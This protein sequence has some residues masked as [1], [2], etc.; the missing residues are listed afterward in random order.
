VSAA[1]T[2][3][4]VGRLRLRLRAYLAGLWQD[5]AQAG[6]CDVVTVLARPLPSMAI[7]E[8][9]GV[10]GDVRHGEPGAPVCR[11]VALALDVGQAFGELAISDPDDIHSAHVPV[12][13]VIAPAHDGAS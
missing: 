9:L 13:P 2:P 10:P 11:G 8:L 4:Q 1:F 12:R 3:R 6:R 7:A 5:I